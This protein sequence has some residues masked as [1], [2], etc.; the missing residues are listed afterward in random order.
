MTA[1]PTFY[2]S[3]TP[4]RDHAPI[5]GTDRE[6]MRFLASRRAASLAAPASARP[7]HTR[8]VEADAGKGSR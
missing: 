3:A 7:S 6:F 2:K 1:I 5:I 4:T 8:A